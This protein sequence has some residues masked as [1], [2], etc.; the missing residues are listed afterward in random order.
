MQKEDN[1][2]A[3][4]ASGHLKTGTCMHVCILD[5]GMDGGSYQ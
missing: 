2:S 1:T 3:T 4:E 5:A